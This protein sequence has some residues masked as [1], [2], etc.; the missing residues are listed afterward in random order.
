MVSCFK[1]SDNSLGEK[2][3]SGKTEKQMTERFPRSG[4]TYDSM[5]SERTAKA[6][7]RDREAE[8][9]RI[10]KWYYNSTPMTYGSNQRES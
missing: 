9:Q 5:S 4:M 10:G 3:R 1:V 6:A 2:K 7:W 8:K